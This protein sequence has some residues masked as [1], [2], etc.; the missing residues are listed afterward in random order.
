M[1]IFSLYTFVVPSA[2][3]NIH[4]NWYL[5]SSKSLSVLYRCRFIQNLLCSFNDDLMFDLV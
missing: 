5:I 4:I 3:Y 2:E 1:A